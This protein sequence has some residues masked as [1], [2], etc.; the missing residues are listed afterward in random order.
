MKH[1]VVLI[2]L[3]LVLAV[4]QG[5]LRSRQGKGKV[6]EFVVSRLLAGLGQGWEVLNDLTFVMPDGE[7]TQID[8]VVVSCKGVFVIET[9][10]FQGSIFGRAGD[11]EWTQVSGRNKFRFQNPIRQNIRHIRFLSERIDVPESVLVPLVVFAGSA[12][13]PKDRPDGVL[14]PSQLASRI[15]S[16]RIDRLNNAQVAVLRGKLERLG[17]TN[18]RKT[19]AHLRGLDDRHGGRDEDGPGGRDRIYPSKRSNQR[20]EFR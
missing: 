16:H 6:G 10:N 17:A 19:A 5:W 20:K 12:T 3:F 2:P 9:K 13:F 18:A 8:H 15:R 4:L 1:L 7:T 14:F 11:A